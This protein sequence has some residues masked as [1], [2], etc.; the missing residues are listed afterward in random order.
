MVRREVEVPIGVHGLPIDGDFSTP[1]FL[2]MNTYIQ[3]WQLVVKFRFCGE[4]NVVVYAVYMCSETIHVVLMHLHKCIVH[5]SEPHLFS[6]V[7]A[8]NTMRNKLRRCCIVCGQDNSTESETGQGCP[9]TNPFS[10]SE[11]RCVNGRIIIMF[12]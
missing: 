1:I 9:I 5:I 4:L 8:R 3:E 12:M 7:Y 2:H 6:T 11:F 10:D